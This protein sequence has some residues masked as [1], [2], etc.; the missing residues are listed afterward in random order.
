M[1]QQNGT[2]DD[3]CKEVSVLMKESYAQMWGDSNEK[4]SYISAVLEKER[5]QKT[6]EPCDEHD[7]D[8]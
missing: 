1:R 5:Y 7:F 3:I 8:Y 4:Y 6:K 2:L